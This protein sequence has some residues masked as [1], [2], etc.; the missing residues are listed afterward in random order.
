[1]NHTATPYEANRVCSGGVAH[2][3]I[4]DQRGKVIVDTFNSEVAEI[5]EEFDHDSEGNSW[6]NQW[7]E[8]GRVD[9]E[10]IKLA[11]N[12]H[13]DLLAVVERLLREDADG[14]YSVGLIEDARA[15]LCVAKGE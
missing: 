4:V 12:A 8:Q 3:T 1:M 6:R 14:E 2:F 10:F 7:D 5:H 9:V 15:A 11:C 13:D